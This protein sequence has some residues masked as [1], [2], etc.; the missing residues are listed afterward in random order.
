MSKKKKGFGSNTPDSQL[1]GS[2]SPFDSGVD[3]PFNSEEFI[4][5]S[6]P[7]I[8]VSDVEDPTTEPSFSPENLDDIDREEPFEEYFKE[9]EDVEDRSKTINSKATTNREQPP[10]TIFQSTNNTPR[11]FLK[12][13]ETKLKPKSLSGFF[14]K[15][16]RLD[17]Y[18]SKNL[19]QRALYALE[20]STLLFTIIFLFDLTMWFFLFNLIFNNGT[21]TF[22]TL[23]PM[24]FGL[25]ACMAVVSIIFETSL[26]TADFDDLSVHGL[27]NTTWTTLTLSFTILI[28]LG[29]I[30]FAALVTAEPFHILI[31]NGPIK[32]ISRV[33]QGIEKSVAI[34]DELKDTQRTLA[35]SICGDEEEVVIAT[36]KKDLS[37]KERR[38][39]ENKI[40][41]KKMEKDKVLYTKRGNNPRPWQ[42][43]D[44]EK[45]GT[46]IGNKE[47]HETSCAGWLYRK[48]IVEDESYTKTDARNACNGLARQDGTRIENLKVELSELNEDIRRLELR[49][50]GVDTTG[51]DEI[52][53]LAEER[54]A[55][56]NQVNLMHEWYLNGLKGY[57][58]KIISTSSDAEVFTLS[59]CYNAEETLN[60][61]ADLE[62][63]S[64]TFL[65]NLLQKELTSLDEQN[66]N[67][68]VRSGR[69]KA[70][71]AV[72]QQRK[73]ICSDWCFEYKEPHFFDQIRVLDQY[74]Y[75]TAAQWPD[76]NYSLTDCHYMINVLRIPPPALGRCASFS[77]EENDADPLAEK[78]EDFVNAVIIQNKTHPNGLAYVASPTNPDT[79]Q[80]SVRLKPNHKDAIFELRWV[81]NG[82]PKNSLGVFSNTLDGYDNFASLTL[83]S[84]IYKG[85]T[86]ACQATPIGDNGE[87]VKAEFSDT[88]E[89]T[90]GP[91]REAVTTVSTDINKRWW[92]YV[93]VTCIG[94]FVPLISLIYKMSAPKDIHKYY[95]TR[96]QLSTSHAVE[97]ISAHISQAPAENDKSMEPVEPVTNHSSTWTSTESEEHIHPVHPVLSTTEDHITSSLSAIQ[98][99]PT[100]PQQPLGETTQTES[101]VPKLHQ[102]ER[103]APTIPMNHKDP[104]S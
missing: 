92:L 95:S 72:F 8:D 90:A 74:I 29:L 101:S 100:I 31:F 32:E 17:V 25:A 21:L 50:K 47:W 43:R 1:F 51:E 97:K 55:C 12:A 13:Q 34:V 38:E 62:D 98:A 67:D 33:E 26:F 80:C 71:E 102:G 42:R 96:Y 36:G 3:E 18:G 16:F 14:I 44:G 93:M 10:E 94:V 39:I 23:N 87:Y 5:D 88:V 4:T 75:G 81:V 63:K 30:M 89:I 35:D 83:S 46:L 59:S 103:F 49:L 52:E 85:D 78:R 70:L 53:A 20:R 40:I 7:D 99:S 77:K 84:N 28:R 91:T 65:N 19:T 79:I 27:F 15:L 57:S 37:D 64:T 66:I 45:K 54:Q 76:R 9:P 82:T 41:E 58:R 22:T 61:C 2:G 56:I 24:A 48:K 73:Q 86:L 68:N 104:E 60:R 69:K 11:I 6:I